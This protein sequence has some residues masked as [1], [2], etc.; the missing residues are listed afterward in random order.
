ME[1]RILKES[2][3]KNL[4]L[5]EKVVSGSNTLNLLK[6]LFLKI[7]VKIENMN[8][9]LSMRILQETNKF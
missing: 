9:D 1:I 6:V 4:R 2:F 5:L 7:A 3:I 8:L